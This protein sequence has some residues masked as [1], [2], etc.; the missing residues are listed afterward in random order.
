MASA[1]KSVGKPY[2]FMKIEDANHS[3]W[4]ESDRRTLLNAIDTFLSTNDP[5]AAQ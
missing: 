1:L 4:R 5:V 2:D 3:L